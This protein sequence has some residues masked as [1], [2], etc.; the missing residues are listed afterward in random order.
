MKKLQQFF[1]ALVAVLTV[2]AFGSTTLAQTVDSG[3]SGAGTI[4]I[5]NASQGQTYTAYKLFDAT[6][7]ADG[8]GISYKLP[9]V[10]LQRIL[11]AMLGLMWTA[12][13]MSLQKQVQI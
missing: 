13:G 11:V 5:S 12:K 7:T 4:T 6:V 10:K 3:K 1:T 2:F 8:S 9:A